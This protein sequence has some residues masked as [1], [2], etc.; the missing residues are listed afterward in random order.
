MERYRHLVRGTFRAVQSG[1]LR[2]FLLLVYRDNI[3]IKPSYAF[4]DRWNALLLSLRAQQVR[5]QA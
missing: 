3:K 2:K 4:L 5:E 1:P